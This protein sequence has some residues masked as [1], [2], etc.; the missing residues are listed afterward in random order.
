MDKKIALN[1][2][3][4][5]A[6]SVKPNCATTSSTENSEHYIDAKEVVQFDFSKLSIPE[7]CIEIKQ[8]NNYKYFHCTSSIFGFVDDL[9]I[10]YL[11]Q[12]QKLHARSESR[13]G[14]SDMGAN[15]KRI[16]FI[17]NGL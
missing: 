7:N 12:E 5:A 8:L 4:L 11:P 2:T 16:K 9:E 10:L 6:C 3:L 1:G 14:H 13:V 15:K 17:F